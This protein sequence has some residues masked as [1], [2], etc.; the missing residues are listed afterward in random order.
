MD[1]HNKCDVYIPNPLD[2]RFHD[3]ISYFGQIS[4]GRLYY[5]SLVRYVYYYGYCQLF[6]KTC[7]EETKIRIYV[8]NILL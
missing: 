2:I 4:A 1:A 7:V 8:Q 3:Y 5:C 6:N